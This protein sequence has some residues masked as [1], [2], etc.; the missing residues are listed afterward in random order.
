MMLLLPFELS[1]VCIKVSMHFVLV[2]GQE[3]PEPINLRLVDYLCYIAM[4]PW[5]FFPG[6]E[7]GI[8]NAPKASSAS[9]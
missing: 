3:L 7:T 1:N 9:I 4:L 2:S 8:T 6:L 5:P